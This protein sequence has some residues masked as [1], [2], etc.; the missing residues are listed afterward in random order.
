MAPAQTG[1]P[2][3]VRS[4]SEEQTIAIGRAIGA[5]LVSGDVLLVSG[6]IGCGTTVFARGVAEG[7]GVTDPVTSPTYTIV[8]EYIGRLPF[9]HVDLYRVAG[10]DEFLVLGLDELLFGPGVCLLEWPE[11]ARSRLPTEARRISIS[12]LSDGAREIR[13]RLVDER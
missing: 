10:H 13:E 5:D 11:H 9:Y 7:L 1:L 3:P 8:N 4:V 2:S 6:P 12:I